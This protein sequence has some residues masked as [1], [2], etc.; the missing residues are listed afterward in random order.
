MSIEN[1]YELLITFACI[2]IVICLLTTFW[3]FTFPIES[4]C[5]SF[6]TVLLTGS[7][8][9][10]ASSPER[11]DS[12]QGETSVR[13]SGT[14]ASESLLTLAQADPLGL[15]GSTDPVVLQLLIRQE[16]LRIQRGHEQRAH[17]IEMAQ[18]NAQ[19]ERMRLDLES[20]R[21]A[22]EAQSR[23]A[24]PS[25]TTRVKGPKLPKFIEWEDIE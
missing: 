5:A 9:D 18:L 22:L 8:P 15:S 23:T 11:E 14:R 20:Q 1:L 16:E 7:S 3:V 10:H 25:V 17:E 12:I 13:P 4:Y 21:L 6:Q 19:Q 2:L 24:S